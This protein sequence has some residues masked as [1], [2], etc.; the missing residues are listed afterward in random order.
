MSPFHSLRFCIAH[1]SANGFLFRSWFLAN[2]QSE[3]PGTDEAIEMLAGESRFY[4]MIFSHEFARHFWRA[5]ST[6]QFRVPAST[7][8]RVNRRGE[9]VEVSR[10]PFTRRTNRH[11]VW[12]YHLRQMVMTDAP[13]EYLCRFLPLPEGITHADG[14]ETGIS[15]ELEA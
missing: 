6:I 11:G 15:S 2:I 12:S 5:G 4:A 7:Y 8:S 1:A 3:W 13:L 9:V 10:K 14:G